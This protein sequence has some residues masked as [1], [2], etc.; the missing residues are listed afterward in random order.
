MDAQAFRVGICGKF[1]PHETG[2]DVWL[3]NE[4]SNDIWLKLRVFDENG[5]ILGETG[6]IK[7]NEYVRTVDL[8]AVPQ[9]GMAVELKFM[10]YEPDTYYSAGAATLRTTVIE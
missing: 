1:R 8:T 10:A 5:Q 6:L 2:V 7:P 4:E 3:Y 9:M